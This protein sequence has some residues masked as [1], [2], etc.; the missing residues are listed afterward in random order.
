MRSLERCKRMHILEISRNA[1]KKYL[2]N[3][4]AKIGVDTAENEPEVQILR[5]RSRISMIFVFLMFS[6][7][8][9]FLVRH[10]GEGVVGVDALAIRPE[11]REFRL[12]VFHE[13]VDVTLQLAVS[14]IGV[15]HAHV[16]ALDAALDQPLDVHREAFVEPEV[17]PT[18]GKLW[19]KVRG[20]GG[21]GVPGS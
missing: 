4:L 17:G 15:E 9:P 20:R 10:S 3:L 11:L 18:P 2:L 19:N 14:K 13:P 8:E 7:G 6:P 16:L 5:A 12:V 21:G 1:E